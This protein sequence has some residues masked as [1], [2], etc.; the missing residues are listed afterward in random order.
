MAVRVT[1]AKSSGFGEQWVKNWAKKTA[2][3]VGRPKDDIGVVFV[4][5]KKIR[6]LN[7]EYRSQDRPTDVL[8]FPADGGGD[9]GDIFIA[10]EIARV[11]ASERGSSYKD[12]LT[13]LIVHSV[14]HLGGYDHHTDKESK[15]MEKMENK[16]L[17]QVTGAR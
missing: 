7:R 11:K 3:A 14:L 10:P 8:S 9:M 17:K 16:I 5:V 6:A 2:L 12:Y 4:G 1:A 13:L 15:I